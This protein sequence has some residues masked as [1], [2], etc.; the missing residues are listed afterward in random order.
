MPELTNAGGDDHFITP[1][2]SNTFTNAVYHVYLLIS[3]H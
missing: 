3:P 2:G 1:D